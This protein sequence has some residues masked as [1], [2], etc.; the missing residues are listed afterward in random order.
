MWASEHGPQGGDKINRVGGDRNHDGNRITG[1]ERLLE[2]RGARI[3]DVRRGPDRWLYGLTDGK[4][5]QVLRLM[6]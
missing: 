4:D 5:G 1:D 3:R 2:E 6:R